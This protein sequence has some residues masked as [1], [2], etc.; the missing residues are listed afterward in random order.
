MVQ[1]ALVLLMIVVS[2]GI[3]VPWYKGFTLLQPWVLTAYAC[4]SVLFVAPA[5]AE[6]WTATPAPATKRSVL[7]R[8]AVLVGYA[9]GVAVLI[10]ITALVTLNVANWTGKFITPPQSL[11][12]AVLVLSLIASA[13]VATLSALLARRLSAATVKA[14]LRAV[15]LLILA[16]LAFGQRLLPDRWVILLSDLSTRRAMTRLAWQGSAILA[17]LG[18]CLLLVLVRKIG[19]DGAS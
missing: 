2:F 15:F 17:V 19:D 3:L 6:F 5:A 16:V 4:V 10:L 1:Q 13:T 18:A 11:C 14:I 8:L 7:A 12:A 9:W